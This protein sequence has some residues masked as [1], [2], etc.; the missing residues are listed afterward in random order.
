MCFYDYGDSQLVFEVRGLE[1]DDLQGA[2]VGNIFYGSEGYVV[3]TNYSS[4]TI[5]DLK[6]NKIT[7]FEGGADHFANFLTAVR[8]RR[9]SDLSCDI[10]EGHLSASLCHLGNISYRLGTE[11]PLGAKP[12]TLAPFRD[13]E[14]T[15]GRFEKHLADNGVTP[16][17]SKLLVG[18]A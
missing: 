18:R 17:Q 14:E 11:Q 6:G 7:H 15:F 2:K 5:F 8:S 9:V 16:R 12:S 4:G 3:S 1:T 10:E 13:A